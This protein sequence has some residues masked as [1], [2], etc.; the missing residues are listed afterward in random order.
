MF[1]LFISTFNFKFILYDWSIR[2]KSLFFSIWLHLDE[3]ALN[4]ILLLH[5]WTLLDMLRI[6]FG[7][8]VVRLRYTWLSY[9]CGILTFTIWFMSDSSLLT[10]I[11]ANHR[12]TSLLAIALTATFRIFQSIRTPSIFISTFSLQYLFTYWWLIV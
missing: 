6:S 5:L 7:V 4:W 2:C 12:R 10:Y 11:R 3:P 8:M 9:L 1:I